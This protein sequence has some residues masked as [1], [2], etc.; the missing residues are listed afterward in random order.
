MRPRVAWP[1]TRPRPQPTRTWTRD[2]SR[3]QA[4]RQWLSRAA[5]VWV[6]QTKN[7][8]GMNYYNKQFEWILKTCIQNWSLWS[9]IEAGQRGRGRGSGG[10]QLQSPCAGCCFGRGGGGGEVHASTCNS[11]WMKASAV[12]KGWGRRPIPKA[13]VSCGVAIKNK[14]K[15]QTAGATGGRESVQLGSDDIWRADRV[16]NNKSGRRARERGRGRQQRLN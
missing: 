10:G 9:E 16:G 6:Q 14:G 2:R 8:P 15:T 5:R 4:G 3:R 11:H 7:T 1:Q 12:E 13:K